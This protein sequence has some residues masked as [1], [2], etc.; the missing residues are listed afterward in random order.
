MCRPSSL[1]RISLSTSI[2]RSGARKPQTNGFAERLNRTVLDG[3]FRMAFRKFYESVEQLQA[4]LDGWRVHCNTE[5]PHQGYRNMGRRPID[6]VSNYLDRRKRVDAAATEPVRDD[7]Q[8]YIF[9]CRRGHH[10]R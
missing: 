6:T 2:R 7:A 5:R 10:E 3:F 8:E 9:D 1:A 4:D